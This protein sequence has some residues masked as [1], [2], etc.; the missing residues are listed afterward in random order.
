MKPR[1]RRVVQFPIIVSATLL[2]I[3]LTPSPAGAVGAGLWHCSPFGD[4]QTYACT[5]ITSA[6]SGGV[7]VLDRISGQI[8]TLRNGNSIALEVWWTDTS[9]RCGVGGNSYVWVVGWQNQGYHY[10]MQGWAFVTPLSG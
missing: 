5:T 9:G 4:G 10:D 6:P 2:A 7:Q 3:V 8:Y 1:W